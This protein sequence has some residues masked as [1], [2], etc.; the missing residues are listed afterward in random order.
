VQ[1]RRFDGRRRNRRQP[2]TI[3]VPTT[4]L[5]ERE[6]RLFVL[7]MSRP[8]PQNGEESSSSTGRQHRSI[9]SGFCCSVLLLFSPSLL[10]GA[11]AFC[12]CAL[13]NGGRIFCRQHNYVSHLMNRFRH[14]RGQRPSIYVLC[15]LVGFI[16]R[17]E[18]GTRVFPIQNRK[19]WRGRM[20]R[21]SGGPQKW[22]LSAF[23]QSDSHKCVFWAF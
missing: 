20:R 9:L 3:A 4:A 2:A 8:P 19:M 23:G 14:H 12:L 15:M 7:F 22:V 5:I 6:K 16:V 13:R 10:L 1:S 21:G 11:N 18:I 17:L